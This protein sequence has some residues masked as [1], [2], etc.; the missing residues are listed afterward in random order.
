MDDEEAR[1]EGRSKE[2]GGPHSRE[3]GASGRGRL[4][5]EARMTKPEKSRQCEDIGDLDMIIFKLVVRR[6]AKLVG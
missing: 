5:T 2:G 6:E 1:K 3:N 4:E